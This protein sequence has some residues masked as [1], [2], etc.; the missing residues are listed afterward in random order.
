MRVRAAQ[1]KNHLGMYVF[2]YTYIHACMYVCIRT[3]LVCVHI[4]FLYMHKSSVSVCVY[5]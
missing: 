5:I 2:T 4:Y 1:Q 3:V